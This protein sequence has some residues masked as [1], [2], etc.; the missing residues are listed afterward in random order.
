VNLGYQVVVASDAV[1]GVPLDYAD[2]VME[3]TLSL[4]A[5]VSTVDEIVDALVILT[6]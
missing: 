1:V 2:A 6:R 5:K 4:V 3:N